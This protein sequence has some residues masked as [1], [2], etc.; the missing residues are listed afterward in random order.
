[1]TNKSLLLLALLAAATLAACDKGSNG[2]QLPDIVQSAFDNTSETAVPLEINVLNIDTG[3][4]S[5]TLYDHL[6]I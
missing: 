2:V 6:L 1:M 5:P 4:E 3:S